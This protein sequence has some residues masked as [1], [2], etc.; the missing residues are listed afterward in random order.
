MAIYGTLDEINVSSLSAS[1]AVGAKDVFVYDTSKDS[2]GGAW[3]KRTQHTSWYNETLNT[4]TRGSR[5]EF[6][7]V[8]VIVSNISYV[9]IYDADDPDLP[10]WMRFT[11]TASHL[12]PMVGY[13][14]FTIG[15]VKA[16]N[17][18][19]AVG[20][21]ATNQGNVAGLRLINFISEQYAWKADSASRNNHQHWPIVDRNLGRGLG[22]DDGNYIRSEVIVG[23]DLTVL[24]NAPIDEETGLPKLT[25]AVCHDSNGAS[26]IRDTGEVF[27]IVPDGTIGGIN[28]VVFYDTNKVFCGCNTVGSGTRFSYSF[29]LPTIDDNVGSTTFRLGRYGDHTTSGVDL[30][31]SAFD[32][33]VNPAGFAGENI[34]LAVSS[35]HMTLISENE[36][37]R[38]Y[39]MACFIGNNYNT[40]WQVGDN[41]ATLLSS[42]DAQNATATEVYSNDFSSSSGWSLSG[43]Y[44]INGGQLS[45]VSDPSGREASITVS[46]SVFTSGQPYVISVDLVSITSSAFGVYATGGLLEPTAVYYYK[47][48]PG[49]IL[50]SFVAT[51]ADVTIRIRNQNS[52]AAGVLDNLKIHTGDLD[53]SAYSLPLQVNGT[54]TRQAVNTGST[55]PLVSYKGWSSSNYMVRPIHNYPWSTGDYCWMG[56]VN[57]N[58]FIGNVGPI[59]GFGSSDTNNG[60]LID[61]YSDGSKTRMDVGYLGISGSFARNQLLDGPPLDPGI[62]WNHFVVKKESDFF[63]LY[64]NGEKWPVS[65]TPGVVDW[66]T[67]WTTPQIVIGGRANYDDGAA[68][69]C[70]PDIELALIRVTGNI[71]SDEQIKK[72]HRDER[73]LFT[74]GMGATYYGPAT[75]ITAFGYDD[76]TKIL[77]VGTTSGRSDFRGIA[78]INNTTDGV[79]TA[80]SASNGLVAEQ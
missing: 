49:K 45:N 67:R 9:D 58:S 2:D 32:A 11:Q 7:A 73:M 19:L 23:L 74:D 20:L 52:S 36:D 56:W 43:G 41:R 65:W 51:G 3:R 42:T 5:R 71:P 30:Y 35:G 80:I 75:Q 12:G 62:T 39:G 31:Y 68:L 66:T 37:A 13:S 22:T 25:I 53:R 59:I 24:P 48:T 72:M 17:G 15:P 79:T 54:I 33:A 26:I 29:V 27:D 61:L 69:F 1:L 21:D 77:H 6:P 60:F 4:A 46:G 57:T 40:G 18:I 76:I 38:S 63:T 14:T 70:D 78:R 28:S 47:S 50:N 10:L 16:K 55:L 8:A 44:T 64:I 34:A